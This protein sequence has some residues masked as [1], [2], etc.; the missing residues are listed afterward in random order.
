MDKI[1][2]KILFPFFLLFSTSFAQEN[3]GDLSFLDRGVFFDPI[4]LDP[5]VSLPAAGIHK[6]LRSSRD[7][8]KGIYTPLTLGF[9]QSFIRLNRDE[10][11]GFEVGL[12]AAAYTQFQ[13]QPWE[14]NTYLGEMVN[15]DYRVSGFITYKADDMVWQLKIFHQSSHLA[16]DYI[17]RNEITTPNP[18]TQNYE[19]A[20]IKISYQPGSVRLY[21]GAGFVYNPNN[22]RKR[23]SF[24]TGVYYRKSREKN[25]LIRFVTGADLKLQQQHNF[26][27]NLKTAVGMELGQPEKTNLAFLLEYYNGHLPF[28]VLEYNQV[29]WIGISTTLIFPS[30]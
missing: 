8:F 13:I 29:N 4:I 21:G 5:Y 14:G 24:Q 26:R 12:E 25:P 10:N 15:A 9:Q 1:L 3:Q 27:P 28:S 23:L 19:Q 22:I 18:G 20:D 30:E 2:L 11:S 17:L 7:E 16:D 6:I